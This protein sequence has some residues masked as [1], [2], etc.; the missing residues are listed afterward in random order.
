[1]DD[2]EELLGQRRPL[3]AAVAL[4]PLDDLVQLLFEEVERQ[5][6]LRLEIV[7]QRA[8]GDSGLSGNGFRGRA[9]KPLLGEQFECRTQNGPLGVFLVL[10]AFSPPFFRGG[11]AGFPFHIRK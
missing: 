3:D 5:V 11:A 7:E 10:D 4:I 6:L 8:F 2:G 9:V 1:M